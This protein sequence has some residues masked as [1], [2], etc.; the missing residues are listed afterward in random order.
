VQIQHTPTETTGG[1]AAPPT[2]TLR[3]GRLL[4]LRAVWLVVAL[5]TIGL[6]LA[7]VPV[8][9]TYLLTPCPGTECTNGQLTP[10]MRSRGSIIRKARSAYS[11]H[12]PESFSQRPNSRFAENGYTLW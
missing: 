8:Y 7:G 10:D 2:S 11:L 4:L 12:T 6:Y 5:P 3:G 9:F 1:L